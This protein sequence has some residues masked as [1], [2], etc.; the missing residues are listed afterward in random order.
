M[1]YGKKNGLKNLLEISRIG[2]NLQIRFHIVVCTLVASLSS[3]LNLFDA[4][5]L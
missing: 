4:L 2:Q 1:N 3:F 5:I